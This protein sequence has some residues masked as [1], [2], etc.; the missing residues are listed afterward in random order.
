MRGTLIPGTVQL[1]VRRFIPTGAGNTLCVSKNS[2]WSAVYPRWRGE[3]DKLRN[4]YNRDTGLSPLARGTPSLLPVS[5]VA[6]RFIPAG[7]GN[8]DGEQ[9]QTHHRAVYPRWRGEHASSSVA[10]LQP[11][12]LS[13]LARGTPY[14]FDD[15]EDIIRFIPAGAG[16]TRYGGKIKN[17]ERFIPAG[18]GNTTASQATE[19]STQVYPRW[20]GEHCWQTMY[21]KTKCGLSPLAREHL[22]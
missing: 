11:T 1:S 12:G 7:A 13:P 17:P 4:R 3:H 19:H 14:I 22:R 20:R 9:R 5:R 2:P 21:P 10:T 6:R 8:T 18:A 16:N 15:T